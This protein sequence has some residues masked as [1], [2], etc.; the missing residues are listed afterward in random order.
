MR[1]SID[2]ISP[3]LLAIMQPVLSFT[4]RSPQPE[5]PV[6]WRCYDSRSYLTTV[7]R[8]STHRAHRQR[9]G[10]E[11]ELNKAHLA[12]TTPPTAFTAANT[13]YTI[14]V[15]IH[16]D[17][18]SVAVK[19]ASQMARY[20][21]CYPISTHTREAYTEAAEFV[22][23]FYSARQQ[24]A[25]TVTSTRD[26]TD[27]KQVLETGHKQQQRYR[28]VLDSGCGTGRS[29]AW[30]ASSYPHL[31]V[32]GIDRS[33]VRLSKGGDAWS[34]RLQWLN[35]SREERHTVSYGIPDDVS[36]EA[37]RVEASEVDKVSLAE[38]AEG[39]TE[40]QGREEEGEGDES[41]NRAETRR[42]RM[43]GAERSNR[44][45]Q[46]PPPS[47][48]LLLRADL[49]DFWILALR[50]GAWKVEEHAILYPN[51]YPKRSQLRRR[52]HGHSIFPVILCLGG[53]I[54]VRSNWKTYLEEMC[55]AVL[56]INDEEKEK[57]ERAGI[58]RSCRLEGRRGMAKDDTC[59]E[60][61]G[62]IVTALE[63]T[64]IPIDGAGDGSTVP[65]IVSV[66][67]GPAEW[68][69]ADT[70]ADDDGGAGKTAFSSDG[71]STSGGEQ[72][73]QNLKLVEEWKVAPIPSPAAIAGAAAAYVVSALSGPASFLPTVPLTNFEEKYMAIGETVYEL[74]L[75][76]RA[77]PA[78]P[79][80][81]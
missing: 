49:V 31:P 9:H 33:A 17:V 38:S 26:E 76:V 66:R 22:Q 67:N 12:K 21:E 16:P 7:G 79:E 20:L 1:W 80:A 2:S 63:F 19:H 60:A 48:L 70:A 3:L 61:A 4:G 37:S 6:S 24:D 77:D 64:E 81:R 54:T 28:V 58:E 32:I 62:T 47:N 11:R 40:D 74:R 23:R 52:W 8:S 50:D 46:V 5:T 53:N 42:R 30:L 56:A 72:R 36:A 75:I 25:N 41:T 15:D 78:I 71:E 65:G 27:N 57:E 73:D 35:I 39:H 14:D 45:G 69:G 55:L 18:T 29:S 10:H 44:K 68:I 51:P 59:S 13:R 34:S 43:S